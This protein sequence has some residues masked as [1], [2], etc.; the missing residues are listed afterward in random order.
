MTD[1]AMWLIEQNVSYTYAIAKSIVGYYD[2]EYMS[3][4]H[5]ALVKTA[6]RYGDKSDRKD[7]IRTLHI[8]VRNAVISA[9]RKAKRLVTNQKPETWDSLKAQEPPADVDDV[10]A[11]LRS[12]V[13]SLKAVG[14]A[15]E[16]FLEGASIRSLARKHGTTLHAM[17]ER[18]KYIRSELISIL[19]ELSWI[20]D[21]GTPTNT[22]DRSR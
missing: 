2:P 6:E 20:D 21:D 11:E 22:A 16:R 1:N 10:F 14:I 19:S 15:V 12:R 13:G 18:V 9:M 8:A 7:F 17:L 3:A 4:A 5:Y